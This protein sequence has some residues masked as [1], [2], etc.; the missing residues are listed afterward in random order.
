MVKLNNLYTRE[1]IHSIFSPHT[2]FQKSR[3]PWG[4]WGYAEIPDRK[5]DY[6]FMVHYGAKQSGHIFDENIDENGT[7]IWQS[8]PRQTLRDKHVQAWINHDERYND[9][10]L[11]LNKGRSGPG[12][13][14]YE[15]LGRL[16]YLDH[17]RTKEKPV[18]F[19]WQLIDWN[20]EIVIEPSTKTQETNTLNRK[21]TPKNI[22]N[23]KENKQGKNKSNTKPRDYLKEDAKNKE[24]GNHGELLVINNEI[25]Y[26]KKIGHNFDEYPVIHQ[27]LIS[28]SS[29]YDIKSYDQNGNTKYIEVKTTTG[30][31]RTPFYMSPGERKFASEN[32]Q[33][34]LLYRVFNYNKKYNTG[35]YFIIGGH[36]IEENFL[37]ECQSYIVKFK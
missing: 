28:D 26:L 34:F 6:V 4:A 18:Y 23:D 32:E 37:F 2:K 1:D 36:D 35:D 15:Y 25:N 16:K 19:Q 7:L 12:Q 27:S 13:K 31:E 33:N 8:Q 11:F 9:I 17:D 3:G 10:H 22:I 20:K 21:E 29:G 24:T 5:G 30:H 14:K